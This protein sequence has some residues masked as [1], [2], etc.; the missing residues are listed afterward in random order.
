MDD[1]LEE[2]LIEVN[3]HALRLAR[4]HEARD[5]AMRRAHEAGASRRDIAPFALL[6]QARVGQIVGEP[7][8]PERWR[9]RRE[10][11]ASELALLRDVRRMVAERRAEP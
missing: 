10:Q 5:A 8:D 11:A 4:A 2:L 9:E 7:A 6:S 1:R 3:K